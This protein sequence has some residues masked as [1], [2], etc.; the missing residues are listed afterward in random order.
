MNEFYYR[1]S[2]MQIFSG[3][4]LS[5]AR[6]KKNPKISVTYTKQIVAS[7]INKNFG[8]YDNW[9]AQTKGSR[10]SHIPA[11]IRDKFR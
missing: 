2:L 7:I 10:S 6:C 11:R 4:L 5:F 8:E 3:L 1:K 9:Q